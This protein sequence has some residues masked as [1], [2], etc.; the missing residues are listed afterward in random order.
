[1]TPLDLQVL[2]AGRG[3]PQA[4]VLFP[5]FRGGPHLCAALDS[6][7]SQED[8]TL[9]VLVSDDASGD[10]TPERLE[11]QLLRY[12]GS[13]RILLRRGSSRLGLEHFP[14]LAEA[15]SC[16]IGIMAHHDDLSLP[17]RAR[18]L[19]DVF[20]ETGADVVA[21]GYDWIGRNG[22]RVVPGLANVPRGFLSAEVIVRQGWAPTMLGAA[23]AWRK[24]VYTEFPR[25]D[26][27]NLNGGHDWL[28]PF[29]ASLGGGFYFI[30]EILLHYRRHEGQWTH[31]LLDKSSRTSMQETLAARGLGVCVAM[32]RD[33]AHGLGSAL[34]DPDRLRVLD[35]LVLDTMTERASDMFCYRAMLERQGKRQLWVDEAVFASRQRARRALRLWE[36]E[37]FRSLKEWLEANFLR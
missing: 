11:Q 7:L 17:R 29:R 12:S 19:L 23:L 34:A 1:M 9:E 14:W 28:L 31:Q 15:A 18:R 33:L 22:P 4:S 6:V 8:V 37:P 2:W 10:D 24:R 20:A 25:L 36:R 16:E 21:S 13:H 35:R 27:E 30:D 5:V 26:R 3:I 32:R